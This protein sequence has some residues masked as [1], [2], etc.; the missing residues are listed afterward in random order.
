MLNIACNSFM[1]SLSEKFN[2]PLK[3]GEYRFNLRK[4]NEYAELLKLLRKYPL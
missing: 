3:E 4:N 1:A 2:L